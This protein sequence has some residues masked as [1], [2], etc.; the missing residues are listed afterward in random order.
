MHALWEAP[1]GIHAHGRGCHARAVLLVLELSRR[2][3]ARHTESL[4]RVAGIS[5]HALWEAAARERS[6]RESRVASER[7]VLV[8]QSVPCGC[9]K[10]REAGRASSLRAHGPRRRY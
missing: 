9:A 10:H 7:A 6:A 4:M 8:V 5:V 1:A 2:S 3:T